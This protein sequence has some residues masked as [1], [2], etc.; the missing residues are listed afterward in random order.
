MSHSPVDHGEN[1][2]NVERQLIWSLQDRLRVRLRAGE[3][4]RW[5]DLLAAVSPAEHRKILPRILDFEIAE[6]REQGDHIQLNDYAELLPEFADIVQACLSASSKP[7]DAGTSTAQALQPTAVCIETDP[8]QPA[9]PQWAWPFDAPQ[10]P[11]E[12]GRFGPY[13]MLKLLGEGGMGHVFLAEDTDLMRR[14]AI[15]LMRKELAVVPDFKQRF[16]REARAMAALEHPYIVPVYQIGEVAETPFLCMPFL[17][18][19]TLASRL[20]RTKRLARPHALK[21]GVQ[22]AEGLALAHHAGLIHRDVKPSN[23]WLTPSTDSLLPAMSSEDGF[24]DIRILDFGLVRIEKHGETITGSHDLL[25]TIEYMSPEQAARKRVDS[26]SDLFSLGVVLYEVCTG[27]APFTR[28]N[29]LLTIQ[30]L[31]TATPRAPR[32]FNPEIGIKLSDL[33]MW[34]L[35]KSPDDRPQSADAVLKELNRIIQKSEVIRLPKPDEEADESDDDEDEPDAESTGFQF[36]YFS[37]DV[38]Q[39]LIA[40]A[41]VVLG[42][43]LMAAWLAPYVLPILKSDRPATSQQVQNE[44]ERAHSVAEQPLAH[45]QQIMPV[46]HNAPP[47]SPSETVRTKIPSSGTVVEPTGVDR[48]VLVD[49]PEPPDLSSVET[50]ERVTLLPGTLDRTS[51][52]DDGRLLLL[53]VHSSDN[54]PASEDGILVYDIATGKL[55][56]LLRMP[57]AEYQ[58]AVGGKVLLIYFSEFERL[59]AWNLETFEKLAERD[60]RSEG[61]I[62]Q[63]VMG[64]G[65]SDRALLRIVKDK[66]I[67]EYSQTSFLELNPSRL[68]IIP[69]QSLEKMYLS[70]HNT[71]RDFMHY[72]SNRDLSLITQWCTSRS[73][74]GVG[75]LIRDSGDEIKYLS[76]HDTEYFLAPGI[77]DLI[78]TGRGTLL[79]TDIA[80]RNTSGYDNK[81][82]PLMMLLKDTALVP[83]FDAAVFI[84]VNPD[85]EMTL[86]P[87]GRADAAFRLGTFPTGDAESP[88]T[89]L[90]FRDAEFSKSLLG[91]DQRLQLIVRERALI[92][93]PLSNDR[94]VR[95]PFHWA[96]FNEAGY[97]LILSVPPK[98]VYWKEQWTYP[99][100]VVCNEPELSYEVLAGPDGMMVDSKGVV[101]WQVPAG[102]EGRVTIKIKI[103]SYEGRELVHRFV[104]KLLAPESP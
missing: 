91:F 25:G 75:V 44:P 102:I 66:P 72:R 22:L 27:M 20:R 32:F 52:A 29:P 39:V 24:R 10:S 92:C 38:D 94:V 84:G 18:G 68:E 17:T 28:A 100:A 3:S 82:L 78:Y 65:S 21:L 61:R 30:A 42:G 86:Y 98:V 48:V 51:L 46:P 64:A 63:M 81:Q 45:Q 8:A 93:L 7:E 11:E 97:L 57:T 40:T 58:F 34:L 71:M 15:K 54:D 95:R 35:S 9:S 2:R 55:L 36:P 90:N 76:N 83:A 26:R 79:T 12:I 104:V 23:I 43:V 60:F 14:V 49:I 80:K 74:Q 56:K 69:N 50:T 4:P 85:G 19:E 5:R 70:F 13:R 53:S 59:Q 41:V 89:T 31:G 73:P 77:D 47:S 33:I 1:S 87:S 62:I 101:R 88:P 96:S 6:R 67:Q 103:T 37:F 99:I 16:L